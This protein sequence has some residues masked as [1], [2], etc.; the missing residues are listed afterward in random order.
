LAKDVEIEELKGKVIVLQNELE[1]ERK[2]VTDLGVSH[3]LIDEQNKKF[4]DEMSEL[5]LE[6]ESKIQV[7]NAQV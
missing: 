4:Q 5:K 7:L 1:L 2:A 6:Y 3:E